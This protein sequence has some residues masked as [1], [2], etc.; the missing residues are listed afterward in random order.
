[1]SKL[2]LASTDWSFYI[3]LGG[4]VVVFAVMIMLQSKKRK[5]AQGEYNTMIDGLRVGAR[6]KTVGGVIG[7][8][9]E[10][11]EE[12]PG[13]RTVLL[14]TGGAKGNCTILYDIQAIYGVV[15]DIAIAQSIAAKQNAD[16]AKENGGNDG[17]KRGEDAPKTQKPK[18][19][20]AK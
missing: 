10:I 18:S 14:E 20:S 16:V 2:F 5:T 1:M 3:M 9:L 15:D 11:R 17:V 7:K 8:I 4:I 6:V 12:A 19:K 13:F